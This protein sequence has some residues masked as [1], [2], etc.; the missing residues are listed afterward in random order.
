MQY[1]RHWIGRLDVDHH[2]YGNDEQAR[3]LKSTTP[4]LYQQFIEMRDIYLAAHHHVD[5]EYGG[6]CAFVRERV[7]PTETQQ[8]GHWELDDGVREEQERGEWSVKCWYLQCMN[9]SCNNYRFSTLS[10][11]ESANA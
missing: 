7:T 9:L 5:R 3:Q 11:E 2:H 10:Q 6:G 8:D 4:C 1:Y